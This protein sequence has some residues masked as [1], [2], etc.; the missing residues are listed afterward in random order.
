MYLTEID[1]KTGLVRLGDIESGVLAIKEFR[2]LINHK[3]YGIYCF[4]AVAL[5][6]DHKSPIK[7]Y[8][9]I[10]RPR[11]AMEEVTGD[12]DKYIWKEEIIQRA[13][14]KYREL[15]YDP[16]LEEGQIH[17][18]RKVNKLEEIKRSELPPE[19]DE[20]GNEIK[21][22]S[23]SQLTSDL[24]AINNDIKE[25]EKTTAGR[26]LFERAPTKGDYNLTRLEQK[27]LKKVSFYTSIR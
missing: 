18:Q 27:L 3:D 9:E 5:T 7:F 14:I 12:R 22:K 13:L 1:D 16:T 26:D 23:I 20:D 10:D 19:K 4:T 21:R 2:D 15:Q 6:A 17:Y 8:N 25:Y 24:R 11:K